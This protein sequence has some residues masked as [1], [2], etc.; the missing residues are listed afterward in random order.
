MGEY[1]VDKTS[2]ES[3]AL[4]DF[5][6]I[7]GHYHRT[8]DIKCGRPRKNAV[9]LFTYIGTPYSITFAEANDGPKG[10][11]LLLTN[12]LLEQVPLGLRKHVSVE[13]TYKDV[14]DPIEG[15]EAHDL[16]WLKVHG[17]A[18]ELD[19][20]SKKEIGRALIGH[21]N[22]KLDKIYSE[23]TKQS[24]VEVAKL[25]DDKVLDTLIDDSEETAKQKTYLKSLWRE[26]L[27]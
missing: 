6:V 21:E 12:G 7:S 2:I 3:E 4:A 8:Q 5:R 16:L 22:F 14:M 9:G 24:I 25:P 17:P 18:S 15:L 11:Q 1:L 19:Q 13:R 23:A 26:V 10:I 27:K 20:L